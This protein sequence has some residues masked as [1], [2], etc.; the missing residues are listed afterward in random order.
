[1]CVLCVYVCMCVYVCVSVSVTQNTRTQTV[2]YSLWQF[3]KEGRNFVR[4]HMTTAFKIRA[5]K[6]SKAEQIRAKQSKAEQSRATQSK[7]EEQIRADK[8]K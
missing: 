7:P 5:A 2:T 1:M 4:S 6:Q 8:S 3:T